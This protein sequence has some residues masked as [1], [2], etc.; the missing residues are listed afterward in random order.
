MLTGGLV[1]AR[2][3]IFAIGVMAIE[4]FTGVRPFAGQTTEQALAALLQSEYH[5]PGT[6]PEVRALDA[7][8]QRCIAKDPRDRYGSAAE[9]A[10]DL[11]PALARCD[12][13]H[14]ARE[15]AVQTAADGP[16]AITNGEGADAMSARTGQEPTT[17]NE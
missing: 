7:I 15:G 12:G 16:T 9:L 2:A 5:L 6:S 3:D 14:P 11:V 10:H 13:L 1:D 8:V 17:S 4:S